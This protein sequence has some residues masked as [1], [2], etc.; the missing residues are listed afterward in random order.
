MIP[1]RVYLKNFLC[2][3]EQEFKFHG[4]P[5][6]LLSGNNGVGKS[7]VFDGMVYALFGEHKRSS[8]RNTAADLVRHGESSFRVEFDFEYDGRRYRIW[9][10]R[11]RSGPTKQGVSELLNGNLVPVRD[12]N[13]V[14]E[15]DDW[16]KHTLGLTY[17]SFVSAVLLRQ[18]AAEKLIDAD[19][20]ARRE[21]F[22]GI[23]D[24]EPYLQLYKTVTQARTEVAGAVRSMRTLLEQMPVV[25][26]HVMSTVTQARN[27]ALSAWENARTTDQVARDRLGHSRHWEQLDHT[28]RDLRDR[29][30]AA[31]GRAARATE[32]KRAVDR[33]NELRL[34]VPALSAVAIRRQE[35]ST[36][37]QELNRLA[38]ERNAATDR[39][40]ST[41]T[42]AAQARQN[43]TIYRDRVAEL[44]K[45]LAATASHCQRL[46]DQISQ[47]DKAAELHNRLAARRND[48]TAFESDLDS[49][50]VE[51]ET[52][53]ADAQMAKDAI[54]HLEAVARYRAQ[55][56]QALADIRTA[57]VLESE[58]A[59]E[60]NQLMDAEAKATLAANTAANGKA[61][62]ERALTVAEER[63]AEANRRKERFASLAGAALCSECGQVIDS[64]HA[65]HEQGKL[66]QAVRDS[67]VEAERC[68]REFVTATDAATSTQLLSEKHAVDRRAA[69]AVRGDA[70]KSRQEADHK[71]SE[72]RTRFDTALAEL[73]EAFQRR[74]CGIDVDGFPTI[75]DLDDLRQ[76]KAKLLG[77]IQERDRLNDRRQA[78]V[79]CA[80][81]LGTLEQA[82]HA[83]GAPTDVTAARAELSQ[84][85][86]TLVGLHADRAQTEQLRRQ[87]EQA[88]S[89]L[90]VILTR[91]T[92][93]V[94]DLSTQVGRADSAEITARLRLTEA[95]RVLPEAY[96]E[97][98]AV[99]SAPLAEELE[100]LEASSAEQD[101]S[102]IAEDRTLHASRTQQ[103]DEAD[104]QIARIPA[105]A[106]RPSTDVLS[107]VTAAEQALQ[108]AD[109]LR[110][111]AIDRLATLT[112]QR[113]D[114]QDTEQRLAAEERNYTLHDR[115]AELLG[116]KG[117]QLDLVRDAEWRI[118]ELANDVLVR[119]SSGD[120]RFDPPDPAS[121]RPFDLTVR[122]AGCPG[123]IAVA[124]LSGG[125]RF[126][127]AVSLA[128]A[129]CRFANG[130][131][132]PLESVIIDEGFGSLD[133]DGRMAMIAELRD[134]QTL[135]QMF[136]R[137]LVV[138]HQEDFAAAFPVGYRLWSDGGVTRA[139]QVHPS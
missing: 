90:N 110:T 15:L 47:A 120:L 69:E 87:A 54:P 97:N 119:V 34:V 98:M 65:I 88:E 130:Q 131:Q 136:R 22:R 28:C 6:W 95:I 109:N 105:D 139:E 44:D 21:L 8:S 42:A 27:D 123:P 94:A 128:L 76:L 18:G 37:E 138:S 74:I 56:R 67:E 50:F 20:D 125:Q 106:R 126:R 132:R 91:L 127:V 118:I 124:N 133:R 40:T 70:T 99:A 14:R 45:Q 7:A 111:E 84:L 59:T 122:R 36:A 104:R 61:N 48:L 23:I 10:T 57:A 39:Q 38:S 85:E 43:A 5:V 83:V 64:E 33:L 113:A 24:L 2:H 1:L 77:C 134:G 107:E 31:G 86:Q 137:V 72:A 63:L 49:A 93:E 52:A 102:A 73:T 51:S 78:R 32:L 121:D 117:I 114:R 12:V 55:Y 41:A 101:L 112:R 135:A 4:H 96:R 108:V 29:L 80:A 129:V 71:V 75:T 9:R 3:Q 116:D 68:R 35:L 82:V 79:T 60:I 62:A 100:Q 16:V 26:D 17:D 92:A 46:R 103:L 115:L 30:T 81:D 13:G 11:A 19:K 89:D 53:V 58:K 66:D 25:T